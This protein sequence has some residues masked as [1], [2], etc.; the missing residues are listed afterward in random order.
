MLVVMLPAF[1]CAGIADLSA[2]CADPSRELTSTGHQ[3]YGQRTEV[4]AIAVE[5]DAT[6][7]HFHVLLVQAFGCAML[8]SD[9]AGDA[10]MHAIL[11]FLM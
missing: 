11:I 9:R 3:P 10:R 1:L 7:H 5:L 6:R 2:D 8:A 4:G